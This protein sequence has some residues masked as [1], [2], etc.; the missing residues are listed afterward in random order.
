MDS[1]ELKRICTVASELDKLVPRIGEAILSDER[2]EAQSRLASLLKSAEA[3]L[4]ETGPTVAR[5]MFE[6][7]PTREMAERFLRELPRRLRMIREAHA[8]A[9]RTPGKVIPVVLES[10]SS[11][12]R[13]G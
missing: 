8:P 1:S 12:S 3:F 2:P 11:P 4:L 7:G 13:A 6:P 10:R 9:R 5:T